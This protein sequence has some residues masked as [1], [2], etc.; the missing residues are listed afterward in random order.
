MKYSDFIKKI[1]EADIA[2]PQKTQALPQQAQQAQQK[3]KDCIDLTE[4]LAYLYKNVTFCNGEID[5]IIEEIKTETKQLTQ[6]ENE[7]KVGEIYLFTNSKGAKFPVRLLSKDNEL[8]MIGGAPFYKDDV[9]E[10]LP[11][12][13]VYVQAPS[14]G[15]TKTESP[16]IT[17]KNSVGVKIKEGSLSKI[18]PGSDFDWFNK[19]YNELKALDSK[20]KGQTQKYL[21]LFGKV[22]AKLTNKHDD[23]NATLKNLL[24]FDYF[25]NKSQE[26]QQT[27][28][29]QQPQGQ[30]TPQGQQ[31]PQGQQTPQGQQQT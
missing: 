14:V 28:Q 7:L 6:G 21:R 20:F 4:F 22:L 1:N 8:K 30:Q 10:E 18:E 16:L 13:V 15:S 5:K 12:G 25:F 29:G 19:N 2:L 26:G 11:D 31:Q 3:P 9:S 24:N 23:P 17:G 27:P